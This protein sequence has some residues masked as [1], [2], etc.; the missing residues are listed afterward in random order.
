MAQIASTRLFLS[1]NNQNDLFIRHEE[2]C[3]E[4]F[5]LCR[6]FYWLW[7]L[8]FGGVDLAVL[9]LVG[10]KWGHLKWLIKCKTLLLSFNVFVSLHSTGELS[11]L[12]RILYALAKTNSPELRQTLSFSFSLGYKYWN[13]K[14]WDKL[15]F[16]ESSPRLK[17]VGR[18]QTVLH[19]YHCNFHHCLSSQSHGKEL[20]WWPSRGWGAGSQPLLQSQPLGVKRPPDS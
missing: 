17:L 14:A 20:S 8:A 16:E 19:L 7:S 12:N 2:F 4:E 6:C 15:E 1:I 18:K 5:F 10:W 3:P 9:L 13:P 11:Q